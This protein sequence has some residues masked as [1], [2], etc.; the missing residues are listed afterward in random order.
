MLSSAGIC[1]A[2]LHGLPLRIGHTIGHMPGY[3]D[4]TVARGP[5]HMLGSGATGKA[6]DSLA[7]GLSY[8]AT[9]WN[10]KIWATNGSGL[11]TVDLCMRV[12]VRPLMRE[13]A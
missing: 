8:N 3:R 11:L 12:F 1:E 10:D 6:R 7:L 4:T 13:S 5:M 9:L 2:S